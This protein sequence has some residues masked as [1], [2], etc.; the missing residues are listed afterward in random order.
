MSRAREE[1]AALR[2]QTTELLTNLGS[3]TEAVGESTGVR[4]CQGGSRQR[5]RVCSGPVR[6]RRHGIR[7]ADRTDQRQ[8]RSRH[9]IWSALV[10]APVIVPVPSPVRSFILRFDR[11]RFRHL[12]VAPGFRRNPPAPAT[13]LAK[14]QAKRV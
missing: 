12:A 1:R 9:H 2:V 11:G 5:H 13:D 3:N 4:R 7:S 10:D 6:E 8:R 14:S